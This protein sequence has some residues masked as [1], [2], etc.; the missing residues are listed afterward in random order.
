M[1]VSWTTMNDSD[2]ENVGRLFD[3]LIN[4][5]RMQDP[6]LCSQAAVSAACMG[7]KPRARR[8]VMNPANTSP[9]PAGASQG[10]AR[11]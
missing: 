4:L 1:S 6:G 5:D 8:P 10:A 7:G 9:D 2:R 11:S 3:A